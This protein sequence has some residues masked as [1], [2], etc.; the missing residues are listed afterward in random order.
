MLHALLLKFSVYSFR[1]LCMCMIY[2]CCFSITNGPSS[3]HMNAFD[4]NAYAIH[5][6]CTLVILICLFYLFSFLLVPLCLYIIR[7]ISWNQIASWYIHWTMHKR[8]GAVR[9]YTIDTFIKCLFVIQI[10]CSSFCLLSCIAVLWAIEC[11]IQ[12]DCRIF[13]F[14]VCSS[15]WNDGKRRRLYSYQWEW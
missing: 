7:H 2:V 11:E 6:H 14:S 1:V 12:S 10:W 5:W 13:I 3:K 9:L 8:M 4:M 15:Q